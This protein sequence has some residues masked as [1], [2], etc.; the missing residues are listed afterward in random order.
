MCTSIRLDPRGF[1]VSR[2]ASNYSNHLPSALASVASSFALGRSMLSNR[3]WGRFRPPHPPRP[4]SSASSRRWNWRDPASPPLASADRYGSW[5]TG[6]PAAH[7]CAETARCMP[8]PL[9]LPLSLRTDCEGVAMDW[10][11]LPGKQDMTCAI[12]LTSSSALCLP[13]DFSGPESLASAP[14][15]TKTAGRGGVAYRPMPTDDAK[16][17]FGRRNEVV[18]RVAVGRAVKAQ[19]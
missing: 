5:V 11:G 7:Y 15:L 2:S 18:P 1:V 8:Q 9:R 12:C 10:S 16:D 13:T 3:N 4:G 17:G 6:W 14:R 19:R